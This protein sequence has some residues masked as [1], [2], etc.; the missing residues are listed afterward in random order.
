MDTDM[1]TG[2]MAYEVG[3]ENQGD[4]AETKERQR[5]PE[6]HQKLGERLGAE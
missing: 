4:A 2:R 1:H 5:F 6:N 3:G